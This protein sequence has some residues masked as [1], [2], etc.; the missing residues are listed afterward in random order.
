MV[1]VT[2]LEQCCTEEA[3]V[4]PWRVMRQCLLCLQPRALAVHFSHSSQD[5]QRK[6]RAD[7][8]SPHSASWTSSLQNV[9]S[10]VSSTQLL[11]PPN[12]HPGFMLRPHQTCF[13]APGTLPS[14]SFPFHGVCICCHLCLEIFTQTSH[15]CI[16]CH[17][18]CHAVRGIFL[19]QSVHVALWGASFPP[20]S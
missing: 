20:V 7:Q 12:P 16:W 6:C 9:L 8:H 19:A 10:P 14:S 18:D 2:I 11:I 4:I 15:L 5:V 1:A 3:P 17:L 13:Y